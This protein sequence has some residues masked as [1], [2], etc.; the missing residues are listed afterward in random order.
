MYRPWGF[1]EVEV[2]RFPDTWH[3]EVVR[4]LA[5]CAGYLYPQEIFLLHISVRGCVNHKATVW[6]EGLCQWKI[7]MTPSG[8][9]PATFWLVAQCLNCATV[10][11]LIFYWRD[12]CKFQTFGS[13][14]SRKHYKWMRKTEYGVIMGNV[15]ILLFL[16][17]VVLFLF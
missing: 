3:M 7:A 8:I 15:W 10:C 17:F 13:E 11:L 5:H 9:E 12:K 16:L 6:L 2:P 1:Q 4:L 14:C